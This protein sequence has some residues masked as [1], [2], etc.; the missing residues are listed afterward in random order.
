VAQRAAFGVSERLGRLRLILVNDRGEVEMAGLVNRRGASAMF[1]FHRRAAGGLA[2]LALP[3]L[4]L[5]D[6]HAAPNPAAPI[7]L[8]RVEAVGAAKSRPIYLCTDQRMREGFVRPVPEI[9]GQPCNVL[10]PPVVRPGVF[11][12]WCQAG[13]TRAV[14]SSGIHGDTSREFTVSTDISTRPSNSALIKPES[15][16][17]QTRHYRFVGDCPSGWAIGDS[18]APGDTAL[19]NSMNGGTTP[20]PKPFSPSAR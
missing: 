18:A 17:T 16:F 2:L 5:V 9:N 10:E 11:V 3:A 7:Q 12:A 20:L 13:D 19:V 8:W 1:K 4:C 14:A 6:A 15:Q